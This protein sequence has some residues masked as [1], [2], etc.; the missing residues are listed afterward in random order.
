VKDK[1]ANKRNKYGK[2]NIQQQQQHKQ[3]QQQHKQQQ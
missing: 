3:Q 1:S 2:N